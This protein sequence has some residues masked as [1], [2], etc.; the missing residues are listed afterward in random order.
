MVQ[1]NIAINSEC[2]CWGGEARFNRPLP[3]NQ[4]NT[5]EKTSYISEKL[6][7]QNAPSSLIKKADRP[8]RQ[9]MADAAR[10][11]HLHGDELG[12]A[13]SSTISATRTRR[14]SIT[15]NP[16]GDE[17]QSSLH[18]L[19]SFVDK[20][21]LQ[22]PLS[23]YQRNN[24]LF[25]SA[26]MINNKPFYSSKGL[27]R[28][29]DELFGLSQGVNNKM[30][31]NYGSYQT[32]NSLLVPNED[33]PSLTMKKSSKKAGQHRS[34]QK[35]RMNQLA[36]DSDSTSGQEERAKSRER[37]LRKRLKKKVVASA[38]STLDVNSS[39]D[40]L[41][42]EGDSGLQP[43]I[44]I[45]GNRNIGVKPKDAEDKKN[46]KNSTNKHDLNAEISNIADDIKEP[47]AQQDSSLIANEIEILNKKS[48]VSSD[49]NELLIIVVEQD[50]LRDLSKSPKKKFIAVSKIKITFSVGMSD[51]NT[52]P[53]RHDDAYVISGNYD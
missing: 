40:S 18:A 41:K 31:R 11:R 39:D 20:T 3:Y 44:S 16:S 10:L 6:L 51:V 22:T 26:D 35:E 17:L 2:R 46:K 52:D 14:N 19:R 30:S 23:R 50:T 24:R 1:W 32:T 9:R 4:F 36:Q 21:T 48:D 25:L 29:N 45:E 27:C 49:T 47:Q 33:S 43:K 42:I 8:W 34:Y 15:N 53:R 28:E 37:R 12:D 5:S 7:L 38:A 13:I